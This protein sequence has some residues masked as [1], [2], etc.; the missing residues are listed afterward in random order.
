MTWPPAHFIAQIIKDR[1]PQAIE[2][3]MYPAPLRGYLR[4]F[5]EAVIRVRAGDMRVIQIVGAS[6]LVALYET[7]PIENIFDNL[8]TLNRI[9]ESYDR[10][11]NPIETYGTEEAWGPLA[12]TG[13]YAK[14]T[15]DIETYAELVTTYSSSLN[16]LKACREVIEAAI[17]ISCNDARR[18]YLK[19]DER[20]V[21]VSLAKNG[22]DS[23]IKAYSHMAKAITSL[24][25]DRRIP[26]Y[27]F[28]IIDGHII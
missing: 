8:N 11:R 12:L 3:S 9:L 7:I 24:D 10:E 18:S 27:P 16:E 23:L 6:E 17:A 14:V 21:L 13:Q 5:F 28:A 2:P 25:L 22:P 26:F 15:A 4:E 1:A 19:N 20:K